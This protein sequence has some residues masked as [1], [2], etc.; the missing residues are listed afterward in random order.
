[1]DKLWTILEWG[2]A[3]YHFKL[4]FKDFHFIVI[5]TNTNNSNGSKSMKWLKCEMNYEMAQNW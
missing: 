5:S 4:T 1:M 2:W 3:I